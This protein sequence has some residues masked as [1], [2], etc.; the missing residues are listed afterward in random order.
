[1]TP[2][3]IK[4]ALTALISLML[5]LFLFLFNHHSVRENSQQEKLK[6]SKAQTQSQS[7]AEQS[8]PNVILPIPQELVSTY[9]GSSP[10]ASEITF[11]VSSNGQLRAQAN[12]E[13]AS[14][15]NDV[16][17]T[18]SGVRKVGADTYIW[19][20]VSGSSA[21]LLPGVTGIGGLGKMQPGFILKG[22]QLTPIMFTGSVDGEIDYSHPN[23][24]PV[25]L[26][27]Q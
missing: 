18:V 1:M 14:D 26:N 12:F 25:S 13:P 23:P 6:I 17:A 4:I 24:Y 3:K 19:E 20:F 11:T 22:G 2:K 16:T 15:I 10:Q 9:K 21:A 27:K 8:N 7:Q 5:A